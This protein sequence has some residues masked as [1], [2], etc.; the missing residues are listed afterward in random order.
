MTPPLGLSPGGQLPNK[1]KESV[2]KTNVAKPEQQ[3]ELNE[4]T[5]SL[6]DLTA[7]ETQNIQGG[8]LVTNQPTMQDPNKKLD[9]LKPGA[10]RGLICWY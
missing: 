9:L 3:V 4:L 2:M 10:I 8:A 7:E 5:P 1:E 6:T